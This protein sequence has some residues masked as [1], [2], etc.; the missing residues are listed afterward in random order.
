MQ[1]VKQFFIWTLACSSLFFAFGFAQ[2]S[3]DDPWEKIN[4]P[5]FEFND[6]LDRYAL[7]PVAKGYQK[8]TP[9]LVRTGIDNFFNNLGDVSNLANDLMQGKLHAAGVDTSRLLFNTT[10]GIFGV[11]DVATA[12]GLQRNDEDFGQTLGKWG[13]SSGPYVVL[14]FLGPS[15]VR[16]APAKI[17]DMFLNPNYYV[18]G[19]AARN[20]IF[21]VNVVDTRAQ[22]LKAESLVSGDKYIFMRN[23]YL[24]NREFKVK[25]GEVEDDF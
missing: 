14:P 19:M 23:A 16:D 21:A 3:D 17:P 15:T 4:R 25:D 8:V 10:F 24:Q 5:V 20:T 13:V 22:L 2:A 12:M 1:S 6:T 9:S 7:K 18:N 11:F